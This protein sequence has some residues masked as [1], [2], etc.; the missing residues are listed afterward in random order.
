MVTHWLSINRSDMFIWLLYILKKLI[1]TKNIKFTIE[2]DISVHFSSKVFNFYI[3]LFLLEMIC[4][5]SDQSEM[6]S[7]KITLLLIVST[8][9]YNNLRISFIWLGGEGGGLEGKEL[10]VTVED[11]Q[12]EE[13]EGAWAEEKRG[14]GWGG[15]GEEEEKRHSPSQPARWGEKGWRERKQEEEGRA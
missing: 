6:K 12:W 7:D 8:L 13:T 3:F 10:D 1:K 11:T 9:L 14:G 2:K 4:F 15:L 5:L